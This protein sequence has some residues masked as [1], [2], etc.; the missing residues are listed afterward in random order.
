MLVCNAQ[1]TIR[2]AFEYFSGQQNNEIIKTKYYQLRF[3]QIC[4]AILKTQ[5]KIS[6]T[7]S[8]DLVSIGIFKYK[9]LKCFDEFEEYKLYHTVLFYVFASLILIKTINFLYIY[10]IERIKLQNQTKTY[11]K[12]L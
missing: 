1:F 4:V 2:A 5:I 7:R 6:N 11:N 9:P 3:I 8:R 12:I 10:L